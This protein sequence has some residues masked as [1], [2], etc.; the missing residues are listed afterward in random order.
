VQYRLEEVIRFGKYRE[1]GLTIRE[2]ADR[3]PT[4]IE[5]LFDNVARLIFDLDDDAYEY[6]E[7][8]LDWHYAER[9]A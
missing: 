8:Q 5:W 1:E 7:R 2:I 9:E 6:Y 3:D 4:Y